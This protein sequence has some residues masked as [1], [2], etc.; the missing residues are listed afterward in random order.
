M[1]DT[2]VVDSATVLNRKCD[3]HLKEQGG[4]IYL[5]RGRGVP[6]SRLFGKLPCT[7]I[8]EIFLLKKFLNNSTGVENLPGIAA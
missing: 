1:Q 8:A 4:D 5:L 3:F 6:V 2:P 7:V